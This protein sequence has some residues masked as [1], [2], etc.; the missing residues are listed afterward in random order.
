M[1]IYPAMELPMP[2]VTSEIV[3]DKMK[4]PNKVLVTKATLLNELK[5]RQLDVVM[6]IGAGDIDTFVLPIKRLLK[7][8]NTKK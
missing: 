4:N 8:R 3:F 2:G 5:T 7:T 1:D 6:T